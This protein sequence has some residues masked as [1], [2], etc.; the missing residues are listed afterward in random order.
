MTKEWIYRATKAEL[1]LEF[2]ETEL[3][4]LGIETT[5]NIDNLRRRLSQYVSKHPET[6][7]TV[8]TDEK[9]AE[10]QLTVTALEENKTVLETATRAIDQ[11]RKWGCH[12]DGK[13]PVAFLERVEELKSAYGIT[14]R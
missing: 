12:F 14:G 8:P 1:I 9:T 7:R 11:I 5:G 2:V 6:F 10:P 3:E 13:N 4:T